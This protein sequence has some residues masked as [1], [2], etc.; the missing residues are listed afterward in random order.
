MSKIS[1]LSGGSQVSA[2]QCRSL[3]AQLGFTSALSTLG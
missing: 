2:S 1:L 3:A